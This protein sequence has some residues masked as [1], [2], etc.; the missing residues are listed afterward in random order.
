MSNKKSWYKSFAGSIFFHVIL[1][2]VVGL[3]ALSAVEKIVDK[4]DILE[5]IYEADAG[6]G[7]GGNSKIEQEVQQ[8]IKQEEIKVQAKAVQD[9][10]TIV[11]K[12]ET[13]Q[14]KK[15]QP[16]DN[17]NNSQ[18]NTNTNS[19]TGGGDG[20]GS[21][22]GDGPGSGNGEGGG[23][24]DGAGSGDGDVATVPPRLVKKTIPVY[25]E[26]ARE[27]GWEGRVI[28]R[29]LVD[30]NGNVTSTSIKSSSGNSAIDQAALICL[31][32]WKFVPAKNGKGNPVACYTNA[33]VD[34]ILK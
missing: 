13:V 21:G 11:N 4:E 14:E 23:D 5:V 31:Y 15:E 30:S 26:S 22:N 29:A 28:V 6:G 18:P 24:G 8:L 3:L 33:P 16:K 20:S 32:K 27:G 12:Q 34:F 25:P 9:A 7:G 19:G 17:N 10:E 2:F 1:F